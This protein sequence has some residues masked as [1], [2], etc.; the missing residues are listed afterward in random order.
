MIKWVYNGA[1]FLYALCILPKI[2]WQRCVHG[3][4]KESF[5]ARL[6]LSLPSIDTTST[7]PLIWIHTV[8]MG[9]TRAAIPFFRLLRKHYPHMR[10]GISSTTQTGHAEAK[11][12]MPEAEAHFFLPFDFPWTVRK[13][14]EHLKP[15]CLIF[16]EGDIWFNWLA[17]AK[18]RNTHLFLINGKISERSTKRFRLVPSFS[19][20]L[21]S[22]FDVLCVQNDTYA[23]RFLSLGASSEKLSVLGNIKLDA[24]VKHMSHDELTHFKHE[25][26]ITPHD[27]LIVIASTHEPEEQ[28]LLS[29]LE[30]VYAAFP[31]LKTIIIPR[32]PE[33][34]AHVAAHLHKRHIDT[35]V[36]SQRSTTPDKEKR[37]VILI[38]AMGL[39]FS[40]YQCAQVALVGG[41]FVSHVGGHNIFEPILYNVP[42]LFGPHMHNQPDLLQLILDAHCGKQITLPEL[43]S[44]LIDWLQSPTVLRSYQ[45]ACTTLISQA[46]GATQHTFQRLFPYFSK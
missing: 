37:R 1:L 28:W 8:S 46:Q 10:I 39:V 17:E 24:P 18:K 32:H 14:L 9:E 13:F 38:D 26:G 23:Q 19:K 2:L 4:Y 43:P 6:G 41:S 20:A 30:P 36:Y 11:R 42:V 22:F 21:F 33:R 34:F 5:K 27:R 29:A 7:K 40:C 35:L 45:E 3:K 15:A 16:V 31:E 44:L 12:S 25:L